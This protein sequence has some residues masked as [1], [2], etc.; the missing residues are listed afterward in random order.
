MHVYVHVYVHV[1]VHVRVH[2][3]VY[4]HVCVCALLFNKIQVAYTL[5]TITTHI[6]PRRHTTEVRFDQLPPNN[7]LAVVD[8]TSSTSLS[9]ENLNR[10]GHHNHIGQ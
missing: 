10:E 7:S 9:S 2:V 5:Y 1:H 4:V 6:Q 3:C 8:K